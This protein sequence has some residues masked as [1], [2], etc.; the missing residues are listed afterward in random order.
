[1]Q[2]QLGGLPVEAQFIQTLQ[3][4]PCAQHR[5]ISAEQ[6]PGTSAA[7]HEF[8]QCVGQ[9]LHNVGRSI[10]IEVRIFGGQRQHLVYPRIAHMTPDHHQ[11]GKV[12][13]H[14]VQIGNRPA[15]FRRT[16]RAGV[17]YLGQK[18]HAQLTASHVDRIVTT[19]IGRQIPQPWH[20]PHRLEAPFTYIMPNGAYRTH[21]IVEVHRSHAS[22]PV[23]VRFHHLR[24]IFI[25][26][27]LAPRTGPCTQHGHP[28]VGGVHG[29]DEIRR[30]HHGVFGCLPGPTQQRG[31][32]GL[33]HEQFAG[34][35]D[36]G[37]NRVSHDLLQYL[38]YQVYFT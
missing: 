34:A 24:Y 9:S 12:E 22:E 16:Q 29:A 25:A 23:R 10:H 13:Q 36:P 8:H 28:N 11:I 2:E 18:R 15:G 7:A 20:H 26:D 14:L 27:Q 5:E 30:T 1:M 38:T 35:L 17:A 6:Y 21:R 31:V 3:T 19:V 37:V 4:T 32:P 33:L